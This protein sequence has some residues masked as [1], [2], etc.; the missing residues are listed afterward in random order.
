MNLGLGVD[1]VAVSRIK[2]ALKNKK[3][4]NKV[5]TSKEIAYCQSRKNPEIYFA[6]RFAAKEAVKKALA[7][8]LK[9]INWKEMEVA[10]NKDGSPKV[11]LSPVIRKKLKNPKIL[12]TLSHTHD[13]AVAVAY[14]IRT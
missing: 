14:L 12:I 6:A 3:F 8:K 10:N 9:K 11:S 7:G 1:I 5:F 2:K 4:K 13:V